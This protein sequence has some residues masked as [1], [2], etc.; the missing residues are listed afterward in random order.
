MSEKILEAKEK[1]YGYLDN[2]LNQDVK[3]LG[4]DHPYNNTTI[5][6]IKEA[7]DILINGGV[8]NE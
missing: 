5:G 1:V 8:F 4:A 2:N 3:I 7:F 6:E